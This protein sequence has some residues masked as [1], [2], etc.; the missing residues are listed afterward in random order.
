MS[1]ENRSRVKFF[2]WIDKRPV[3]MFTTS[4]NHMCTII[5]GKNDEVKSDIFL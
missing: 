2:K 5:Q 4:K 1:F 3:Y